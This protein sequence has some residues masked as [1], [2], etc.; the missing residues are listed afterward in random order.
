MTEL[1]F[2]YGTLKKGF[3]NYDRL[4]RG[5]TYKGTAVSVEPQFA[6][7]SS[8]I[9]FLFEQKAYGSRVRGDLFEVTE[10]ELA[11]CDR[12]E[13]HPNHY[14][15]ERHLFAYKV[16]DGIEQVVAWVYLWPHAAD[17]V[18]N[19]S[20]WYKQILARDGVIEWTGYEPTH[21]APVR[22][23]MPRGYPGK[24]GYTKISVS[25][26]DRM[27][28]RLRKEAENAEMKFSEYL[29]TVLANRHRNPDTTLPATVEMPADIKERVK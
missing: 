29:T 11:Q 18:K 24:P 28:D 17:R 20:A 15:R 2:V 9:P 6:M 10:T 27:F 14:R 12:L 5:A 7:W 8:G 19:P 13:G 22:S 26:P 25:L 21:V 1:L 3:R 4:L 23:A 16:G